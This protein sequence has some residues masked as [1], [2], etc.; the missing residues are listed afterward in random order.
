MQGSLV[1]KR[2][3]LVDDVTTTG[4]TLQ[5]CADAVR[6]SGARAIETLALARREWT[7]PMR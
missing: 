1:D 7:E 4:A 6:A 3:L 2:V 5:A